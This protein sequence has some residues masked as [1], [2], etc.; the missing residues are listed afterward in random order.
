[1]TTVRD[2]VTR[3]FR[4]DGI[5][6]QDEEMTAD[7]AARGLESFNGVMHSLALQGVNFGHTDVALDDA[8]PLAPQF[9]RAFVHML[10]REIAPDFSV[11]GVSDS[12]FLR[13]LQAFYC[14]VPEVPSSRVLRG[15]PSQDIWQRSFGD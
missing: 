14:V 4:K 6:A 9:Q 5:T 1:M 7:Q 2:I 10:A 12:E 11:A 13:Q 8:F 3:A 15:T